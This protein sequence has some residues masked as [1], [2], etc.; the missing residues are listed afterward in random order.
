[1]RRLASITMCM[2][3]WAIKADIL[4]ILG[5]ER[6]GQSYLHT[7]FTA[8]FYVQQSKKNTLTRRILLN[9]FKIASYLLSAQ[10]IV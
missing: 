5:E 10:C 4:K 8:T 3:L 6:S 1:M 7:P 2:L 9:E